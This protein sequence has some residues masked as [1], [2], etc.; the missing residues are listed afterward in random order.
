MDSFD[1]SDDPFPLLPGGLFSPSSIDE[2]QLTAVS[3]IESSRKREREPTPPPQ[4]PPDE[5]APDIATKLRS[6]DPDTVVSTLNFLLKISADID[7]NYQLGRGGEEVID[8]LVQLFDD[9]IGWTKGSAIWNKQ[10]NLTLD[11]M[12]PS[13]KSW[14]SDASP[15]TVGTQS[16]E[17]IDCWETFCAVKFAQSTG[18]TVMNLNHVFPPYLLNEEL[19]SDNIKILEIIMM[20][21]RNLS[22]GK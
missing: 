22:Y 14:E 20:I 16:L 6:D 2:P 8:A 15:S 4:A 5:T 1:F 12:K 13:K 7:V 10:D 3:P 18:N 11:F 21:V 9:T 19:D 17:T